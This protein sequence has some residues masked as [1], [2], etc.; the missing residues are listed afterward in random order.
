MAAAQAQAQAQA[1]FNQMNQVNP[2][3]AQALAQ[4]QAMQQQPMGMGFNGMQMMMPQG[5]QHGVPIMP[6]QQQMYIN[7]SQQ[8]PGT[9]DMSTWG[10]Q[11]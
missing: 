1:Q 7:P 2:A 3:H 11:T 8:N 9:M 6:G 5:M 4:R 10:Y